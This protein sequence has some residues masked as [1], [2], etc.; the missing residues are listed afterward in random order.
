MSHIENKQQKE[1]QIRAK[2]NRRV[3]HELKFVKEA[4]EGIPWVGKLEIIVPRQ[5]ERKSRTANLRIRYASLDFPPP[6]NRAKS[7]QHQSVNLR[8]F[9][10]SR[11]LSQK[12]LK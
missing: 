5:D 2:H 3:N 9:M 11:D 10:D 8:L 1:L 4:I 12:T 6:I 7:F